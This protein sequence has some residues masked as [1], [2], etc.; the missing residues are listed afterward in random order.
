MVAAGSSPEER[1]RYG[2]ERCVSRSPSHDELQRLVQ[3]YETSRVNYAAD[4]KLAEDKATNPIGAPPEDIEMADLA[5]LT[6]AANVLL[7]LDEMLMKR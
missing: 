1:L 4:D 3:L 7:N 6:L 2:S 5:A